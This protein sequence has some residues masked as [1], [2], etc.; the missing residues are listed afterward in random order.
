[1]SKTELHGVNLVGAEVYACKIGHKDDSL[2]INFL[3]S[4]DNQM[5]VRVRGKDGV[6][7]SAVLQQEPVSVKVLFQILDEIIGNEWEGDLDKKIGS[8]NPIG[9]INKASVV[10]EA[11]NIQPKHINPRSPNIRRVK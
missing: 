5:I 7:H 2:D 1:M 9:D 6:I 10:M 4:K 3:K 8:D 11:T